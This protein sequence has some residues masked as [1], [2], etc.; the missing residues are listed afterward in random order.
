MSDGAYADTATA[1]IQTVGGVDD[2]QVGLTAGQ[3]YYIQEDGTLSTEAGR[4]EVSAGLALSSTE[5]LIK[6]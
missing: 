4:V 6:G 1:T 3:S 5:L 2:S